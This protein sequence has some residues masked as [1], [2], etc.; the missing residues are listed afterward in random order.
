MLVV[1]VVVLMEVLLEPAG[2]VAVEMEQ[3]VRLQHHQ[4]RH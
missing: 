1:E 3:M 4:V 2:L